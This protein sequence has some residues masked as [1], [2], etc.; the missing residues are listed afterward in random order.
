MYMCNWF[1]LL[2]SRHWHSS[3]KQFHSWSYTQIKPSFKKTYT[4]QCSLQHYLQWP[5]HG[6]NLDVHQQKKVI[7]FSI[8]SFLPNYI[9]NSTW[10]AIPHSIIV[11]SLPFLL[12]HTGE[13]LQL[14]P[15]NSISSARLSCDLTLIIILVTRRRVRGG[16]LVRAHDGLRQRLLHCFQTIWW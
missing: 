12:I 3:V 13:L 4:P 14:L 7:L 11:H 2:Y 16:I 1:T 8:N 9:L 6:S 10:L 15:A 5:G